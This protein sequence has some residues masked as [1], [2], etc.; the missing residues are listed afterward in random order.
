[1]SKWR[2][3]YI[4]ILREGPASEG[5]FE[6]A[7]ELID[8]G[9]GKGPILRDSDSSHGR[10]LKLM[11]KG[12]TTAGREYL[13]ELEEKVRSQSFRYRLRSGFVLVFGWVI[14]FLTQIAVQWVGNT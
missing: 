1:M 7:A 6:L 13:D 9:Y 11:W 10:V 2:E 14:G 5:D 8:D 4:R 3:Q 12:P